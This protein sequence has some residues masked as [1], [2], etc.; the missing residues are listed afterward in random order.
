MSDCIKQI[1]EIIVNGLSNS[2]KIVGL[3]YSRGLMDSQSKASITL[4]DPNNTLGDIP[5]ST[6]QSMQI[7]AGGLEFKGFPVSQSKRCSPDGSN[8]IEIEFVDGSFIL[9]KILVGLW[10][11]HH[12]VTPRTI[13]VNGN[14]ISSWSRQNYFGSDPYVIV[15]DFIDPCSDE[16]ID[17]IS[18]PCDPCPDAPLEFLVQQE[19]E[20]RKIDCD[21]LRRLNILEVDY[22]FLDLVTAVNSG[23]PPVRIHN[24]LSLNGIQNYRANYTGTLREVLSSWCRD[25]GWGFYWDDGSIKFIDLTVGIDIDFKNLDKSCD[26]ISIN[27]SKTLNGVSSNS[28]TVYFGREGQDRDY[29]CNYEFGKRIVCRPLNLKD[30]I[31][32]VQPMARF[33]EAY[34]GLSGFSPNEITTDKYDLTE[35]LCVCS[36]YH[37]R[38]RE[39]VT[40]FNVYGITSPQAAHNRVKNSETITGI[41]GIALDQ[42]AYEELKF[43]DDTDLQRTSLPLLDLSVKRVF[44][45]EINS[46]G[47]N[48][49]K[50][51]LRGEITEILEKIGAEEDDIYFFIGNRL[52]EKFS[53][54]YEWE[55][56][57]A[58]D[59]LGKFF[60]RKYNS[61]RGNSPNIT[62]AGGDSA[63][64]YESG[65]P[66]LDFSRFFVDPNP[67][68]YIDELSDTDSESK[69]SYILVERNPIWHPPYQQGDSL[70][71]LIALCE[72]IVPAEMTKVL[73][74]DLPD[75]MDWSSE[76][77][78][79]EHPE[80]DE[81][82]DQTLKS[83]G[84]WTENDSIFVAFKYKSSKNQGG[85]LISNLTTYDFHPKDKA[86][87]VE[88]EGYETPVKLGLRSTQAKTFQIENTIFWMPPQS[89][90]REQEDVESNL[91]EHIP[92]PGGYYVMVNNNNSVQTIISVPKMEIVKNYP[93]P[94]RE[95]TLQ[96]NIISV[97]MNETDLQEYYF[98]DTQLK[99][100]IDR[101]SIELAMDDY[102]K[103]LLLNGPPEIIEKSIEIN[104]IPSESFDINDGLVSLQIRVYSDSPITTLT[105]R[106]SFPSSK[107]LRAR[108]ST[109]RLPPKFT[110]H[111]FT[112]RWRRPPL[113][114]PQEGGYPTL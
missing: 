107:D 87:S 101:E 83:N 98:D 81:I 84:G 44:S 52:E 18:D 53:T 104:G 85:L 24:T 90:V 55:S 69:D 67:E 31:S 40:W 105:F 88:I 80:L 96:N 65:T 23:W 12:N 70:E 20:M 94:Y 114:F 3:D 102:V 73:S 22:S 6:T 26:V 1:P 43:N 36:M 103:P 30:L 10:G 4:I 48:T 109:R 46:A 93:S 89:T 97:S 100:V 92:Y 63:Q 17:V 27:E 77:L 5:L 29:Q 47:F 76:A 51:A 13:S 34:V 106:N 59:F 99:C 11:K 38:I 82:D 50:E 19:I 49:L 9:D 71:S 78:K 68:S 35:F 7:R 113:T 37:P 62:A 91:S 14:T 2:V 21:R 41:P 32:P 25:F 57:V 33:G 16:N 8:E 86:Q 111:Q 58:S 72:K 54:R 60:I 42:T 64:Y 74:L 15:G 66:A 108:N 112:R 75:G 61:H 45:S 28:V 95:N 79:N 56:N 39:A 110:S